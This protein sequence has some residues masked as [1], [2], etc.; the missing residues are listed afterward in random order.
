M[1]LYRRRGFDNVITVRP[2]KNQ[3]G[4]RYRE[5][6]IGKYLKI[7]P[8]VTFELPDYSFDDNSNSD[9][10]RTV[11]GTI[12]DSPNINKYPISVHRLKGVD[13]SQNSKVTEILDIKKNEFNE[14][15]KSQ[16]EAHRGEGGESNIPGEVRLEAQR[17]ANAIAD[18]VRAVMQQ[19]A[20]IYF[21][22]L[23]PDIDQPDISL[24]VD[25]IQL[26]GYF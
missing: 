3:Q 4:V 21:T 18:D 9:L 13:F 25:I 15:K 6:F 1:W 16:E 17:K 22:H 14:W 7:M 2:G 11:Y 26:G 8:Y 20:S 19:Q 12:V 23:N 10:E 24:E 5:S